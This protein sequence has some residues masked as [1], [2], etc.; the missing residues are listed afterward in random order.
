M[1]V[2]AAERLNYRLWSSLCTERE[3]DRSLKWTS[4]NR[5]SGFEAWLAVRPHADSD[6]RYREAD[7]TLGAASFGDTFEYANA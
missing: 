6:G 4:F 5:A 2:L 1:Q 7:V 3:N